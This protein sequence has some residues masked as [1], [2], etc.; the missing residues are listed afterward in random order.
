MSEDNPI[1]FSLLFLLKRE[2]TLKCLV[3]IQSEEGKNRGIH[4]IN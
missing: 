4:E 3:F 1:K 2:R